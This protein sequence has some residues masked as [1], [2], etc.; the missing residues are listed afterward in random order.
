MRL[1]SIS[2]GQTAEVTVYPEV[3]SDGGSY[4][5]GEGQTLSTQVGPAEWQIDVSAP[6]SMREFTVFSDGATDFG[7]GLARSGASLDTGYQSTLWRRQ[8]DGGWGDPQLTVAG[9]IADVARRGDGWLLVGSMFGVGEAPDRAP[10]VKTGD[11]TTWTDVPVTGMPAN[12]GLSRV[13]GGPGGPQV[14]L[15]FQPNPVFRAGPLRTI[16]L[17]V[18]PDASWAP[19]D[20]PDGPIGRVVAHTMLN[21]V[22]LLLA[23]EGSEYLLYRSSDGLTF[24]VEPVALPEG[25]AATVS[26]LVAVDGRL[27]ATGAVV[28]G[29]AT[30]LA[31]WTLDGAAWTRVVIDNPPI[32]YDL[33]VDDAI[34]ESDGTLLVGGI[35]HRQATAWSIDT[36]AIG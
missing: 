32:A 13:V 33:T 20:M 21:G 34:V 22:L 15:G 6:A 1:R 19:I 10:I 30:Q 7:V 16:V 26:G 18:Q 29:M 35:F 31:M 23:S 9:A 27:I 5:W 24:T 11:G 3:T 12:A 8:P 14:V 2:T 25:L 4:A 36:T 28:T 17:G